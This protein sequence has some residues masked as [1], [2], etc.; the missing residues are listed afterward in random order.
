MSKLVSFLVVI[1]LFCSSCDF[2]LKDNVKGKDA[3]IV[4]TDGSTTIVGEEDN[5]GCTISAGYRWSKLKSE[6]LRPF[7]EG[8]RLNPVNNIDSFEEQ[9][10]IDNNGISCFVILSSDEKKAEIFVPNTDE[11]I[12]LEKKNLK[13]VLSNEGW[14]LDVRKDFV[15][16]RKG[17][18]AY[19]AARAID[20]RIIN[21]DQEMTDDNEE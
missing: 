3:D 12:L 16:K 4:T 2:I 11:S 9:N 21:S 20:L 10:D 15:L 19:T 18:V 8:F 6:C 17:E 14:E 13:G 1:A 7:E 5:F